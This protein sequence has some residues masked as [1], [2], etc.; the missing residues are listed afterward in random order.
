MTARDWLLTLRDVL[1]AFGL[2][3]LFLFFTSQP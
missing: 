1:F 2:L 3:I